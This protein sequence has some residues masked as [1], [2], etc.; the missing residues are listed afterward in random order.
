[1]KRLAALLIGGI[2]ALMGTSATA[3]QVIYPPSA[4]D[5]SS[6]ATTAAVNDAMTAAL[7][8]YDT[9]TTR[10]AAVSS[11]VSGLVST[12]GMTSALSPYALTTALPTPAVSSPPCV[13]DTGTVGTG[14][15]VYALANHT[16]CSKVRRG[17]ANT[18]AAGLLTVA[19]SPAFNA[20]PACQALAAPTAGT[21][22]VINAQ[23]D[24]DPTVSA[25]TFRITRTNRS[26]VALIGLTV[27]SVPAPPGVTK[28]HYACVEP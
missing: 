19:F 22:D 17:I 11:A 25:A 18:D 9:I 7:A 23:L 14:S 27:L 15:S 8:P 6:Y 13:A 12:S 16:H 20:V 2:L 24:G 3:R 5:L 10:Q 21:T 1:M 4:V 26:V 28:L